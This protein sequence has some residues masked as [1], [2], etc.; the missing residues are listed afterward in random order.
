MAKFREYS[1][2][3]RRA[4]APGLALDWLAARRHG[5]TIPQWRAAQ[6][7]HL[8]LLPRLESL[9]NGLVVDIGANVGDWTASV[10]AVAPSAT[11]VAVEPAD[12]P[13]ADLAVRFA[14]DARVTID[15]RAVADATG[16]RA[17]HITEH[18]HN[19]S[20]RI[21]REDMTDLYGSGWGVAG[22]TT[23]RTT[24]VDDLVNGRDVAL[25]KIDVQG[26]EREVLAGARRSLASTGAILIEVTFVSHYDGD[27][28]FPSLHEQMMEVDFELAGLSPPFMSRRGTVL[29]CDACYVPKADG[30]GD[31]VAGFR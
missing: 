14:N 23:V 1:P 21:P 12:G 27:A 30:P 25:L 7:A 3:V 4:V 13:R 10:L 15:D 9:S 24:T 6:S 31:G 2:S 20:L 5:L 11:V 8:D 18:S 28:T 19:A 29:W 17:F 16:E 26:G 22:V